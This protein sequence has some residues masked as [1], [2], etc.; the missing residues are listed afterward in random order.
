MQNN[1]ILIVDRDPACLPAW[2]VVGCSA[3]LREYRNED[4]SVG[5]WM[6]GLDMELVDDRSLCCSLPVT[7][8]LTPPFFL[9]ITF[10]GSYCHGC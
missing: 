6:L 8:C 4:V 1:Y 3:S 9:I 7:G 2:M 5:G 10:N